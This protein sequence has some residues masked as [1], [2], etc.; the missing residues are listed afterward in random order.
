MENFI[1]FW[2]AQFQLYLFGSA[3]L[4]LILGTQF[5]FRLFH[6]LYFLITSSVG[7]CCYCFLIGPFS[8]SFSL[9]SFVRYSFVTVDSK[10]NC[11]WQY[12]NCRSP[13]T[14]ETALPVAPQ[15]LPKLLLLFSGCY[16]TTVFLLAGPSQDVFLFPLIP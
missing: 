5:H 6:L 10:L 8:A 9:F 11:Q 2:R 1:P 7:D 4:Y 13:E 15:P 14:E 12:S 16:F 3:K